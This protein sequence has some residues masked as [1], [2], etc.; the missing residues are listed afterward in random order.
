MVPQVMVQQVQG[1]SRSWTTRSDEKQ[2]RLR[3][4]SSWMK[5]P[6]LPR[7][8]LV[9]FHDVDR[10][11]MCT[12]GTLHKRFKKHSRIS[13]EPQAA[14]IGAALGS[15]T[16]GRDEQPLA[17]PERKAMVDP[18]GSIAQGAPQGEQRSHFECAER[19]FAVRAAK[20]L[21][22]DAAEEDLR[23]KRQVIRP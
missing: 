22:P 2:R 15:P 1:S 10:N 16:I 20:G 8:K 12:L 21:M 6:H 7:D 13:R 18:D 4:V 17:A 23:A 5:G 14:E 9:E 19:P 3:S 11:A